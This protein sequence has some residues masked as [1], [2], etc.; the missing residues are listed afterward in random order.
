MNKLKVFFANN[1]S[2]LL[3]IRVYYFLSYLYNRKSILNYRSPGNLSETIIANI[4]SGKVNNYAKF[5]DKYLVRD[6]VSSKNLEHILPN[7]YGVWI[8]PE[9]IDYSILP[10]KFVLKLNF[11]CGFNI[12]CLDKNQLQSEN[13]KKQL[14]TWLNI[15]IFWRAEPHYDL[16][17]RL[18]ICEEFIEDNK[19][20]FPID[21]KFM[22]VNGNPDHILVVIDR[23]TEYKLLT[24]DLEWNKIDL[25]TE[26]YHNDFIVQRP[27]NLSQMVEYARI[28][29]S[30]FDF[31]R[32]DLYDTGDR[33][34]FGEL[35]FTPQGGLLRYYKMSA[36]EKMK[37]N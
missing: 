20:V 18:I 11:G 23:D 26:K 1:I 19:G 22:C 34:F 14:N 32:V 5:T 6:Y 9:V 33:I 27:N 30:E 25:L 10:N 2:L 12:I 21:Y 8:N 24:Y 29:S 37:V 3:G 36:L 15:K 13:V 17:N 28:L 16:I 35:T 4:I 7:L 31:V